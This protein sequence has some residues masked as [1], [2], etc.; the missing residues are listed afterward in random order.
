M[1]PL[2][3]DWRDAL[4]RTPNGKFDRSLL[5]RELNDSFAGEQV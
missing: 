3:V 5:H 1:V 2:K 4:P